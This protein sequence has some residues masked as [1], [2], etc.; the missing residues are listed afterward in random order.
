MLPPLLAAVCWGLVRTYVLMKTTV[1]G[2]G[3]A[4]AAVK[5]RRRDAPGRRRSGS[6]SVRRRVQVD[7]TTAPAPLQRLLAACRRAFGGPGTVPSPDDVALIRDILGKY[8]APPRPALPSSLA[9]ALHDARCICLTNYCLVCYCSVI[10]SSGTL[11]HFKLKVVQF[12][13]CETSDLSSVYARCVN[14]ISLHA[15]SN[16]VLTRKEHRSYRRPRHQPSIR[17]ACIVLC[18]SIGLLYGLFWKQG[19]KTQ[20]QKT[21]H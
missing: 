1:E 17:L 4:P 10:V 6:V 13:S 5:R 9:I 7:A 3:G 19:T 2:S 18:I 21:F 20:G 16:L 12:K 14:P 8:A 15:T 11:W